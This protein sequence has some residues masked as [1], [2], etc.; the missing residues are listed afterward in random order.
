MKWEC[1]PQEKEERKKMNWKCCPQAEEKKIMKMK[2]CKQGPQLVANPYGKG[3]VYLL[4]WS[5]N[6]EC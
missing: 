4:L 1:C 3:N 2:F 6:N 5:L